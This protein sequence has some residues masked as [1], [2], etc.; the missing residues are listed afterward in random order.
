MTTQ[1]LAVV[2][3]GTSDPSTTTMLANQAP[4]FVRL[5]DSGGINTYV[6]ML[7][8]GVIDEFEREELIERNPYRRFKL[9]NERTTRSFLS[10]EEL[11][12]LAALELEL[13]TALDR[14]RD[15]FLFSVYTGLR[16]SDA[17]KLTLSNV[18]EHS[19]SAWLKL[20]QEKTGDVVNIPLLSE[21][22]RIVAKYASAGHREIKGLLLP[23]ISNQKLNKHLHEL[24]ARASLGRSLTHHVARHTFATTITLANDVPI[25]VVSKLLGH[26]DL[27]TTQIYAKIT[28]DHLAR[29]ASQLEL[30][31]QKSI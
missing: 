20:V 9:K 15:I 22:A 7:D 17:I 8:D 21:A 31:L 2:T 1:R 12:K 28:T 13:G 14:V 5:N 18:T 3:A 16:Y 10:S 27:A 30:K 24:A 11:G 29:V 6:R 4:F 26:R 19:G 25:E 23:P